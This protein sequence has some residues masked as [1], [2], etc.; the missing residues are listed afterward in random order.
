MKQW[1]E[2]RQPTAIRI[3]AIDKRFGKVQALAQV[4][5]EVPR[6]SIFGLLGPN[7]AGKTTLFSIIASFLQADRGH[8]EVLG[9][10]VRRRISALRGRMTILPQDAEFERNVPIVEQL[11][12]FRMLDGEQREQA[13]EQV[14]DALQLVGLDEWAHRGVRTLSHG[15]KKR[16]GIAQAFLGEPELVLLDEPTA[17]LDPANARKIRDLVRTLHR[18]QATIVLSSHNIAEV[19]ELCDHV[20]ILDRGKLVHAGSLAE[21]TCS[22]REL[23]VRLSRSLSEAEL[24]RVRALPGVVEVIAGELL[25]EGARYTVR[26]DLDRGR[27]EQAVAVVL[28]RLLEIGAVPLELA[29]GHSLES[30]F[31]RLTG[32]TEA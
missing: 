12:L 26:L 1:I 20:A 17:G 27:W 25:R 2:A 21:L 22:G 11:T 9:V 24:E 14:H 29:E 23:D 32:G 30:Q 10:N 19:Q 15:M 4:S 28:G 31:L 18:R 3:C 16:L 8:V 5:F 13:C 7:G 6:G